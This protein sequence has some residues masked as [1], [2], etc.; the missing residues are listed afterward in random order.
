M[1]GIRSGA[2]SHKKHEKQ[3]GEKTMCKVTIKELKTAKK[4][5]TGVTDGKPWT[6]F[7]M[8]CL[9]SIE[10]N[11]SSDVRIV[12]TFEEDIFQQ[13]NTMPEGTTLTFDADKKPNGS[14]YEYTLKKPKSPYRN[15]G[16][17][18]GTEPFGPTN[19]QCCLKVAV[20]LER[21]RSGESGE[22]PTTLKILETAEVLLNWL[23][24]GAQ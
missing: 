13:I 23:E 16:G 1:V 19:R 7:I 17:R 5:V 10:S 24:G 21:A 6:L 20:D 2:D 18:N 9:V 22:I 11:T 12:K 14:V 8:E 4:P 3:Q 15:K